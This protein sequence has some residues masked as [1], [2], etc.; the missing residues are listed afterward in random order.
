M[1]GHTDLGRK[2][3]WNEMCRDIVVPT[4]VTIN[5]KDREMMMVPPRRAMEL[6]HERYPDELWAVYVRPSI[7]E[8]GVRAVGMTPAF[9]VLTSPTDRFADENV[10]GIH[11]GSYAEMQIVLRTIQDENITLSKQY[12]DTNA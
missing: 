4:I 8:S 3:E 9:E 11:Y 1:D 10:D 7:Q 5:G 2:T 6:W 12:R